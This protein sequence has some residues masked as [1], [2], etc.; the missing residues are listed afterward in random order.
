MRVN[1]LMR[2]CWTA[3][4]LLGLLAAAGAGGCTNR[5][6]LRAQDAYRT[7]DLDR[8][9]QSFEAYAEQAADSG[10][11]VLAFLELGNIARIRGDYR[12]S[13]KAFA[14]AEAAIEQ[15]DRQP[16]IS[17]SREA[18]VTTTNLNAL[19][20]RASHYDRVMLSV[21]RA[22]NFMHLG[23]FDAARVELRR[24]Y[25][26]QAEAVRDN[27]ERIEQARDAILQANRS[28]DRRAAGVDLSR[29]WSSPR[30]KSAVE[31]RF[32]ELEQYQAYADYVNPFAELLQGIFLVHRAADG[33]DLERARL[34]F[35][36]VAGMVPADGYV[37]Q[38]LA[39]AEDLARGQ[40]A[41]PITYVL[42]E[43]GTAPARDQVR[44]NLP[45]FLF[46]DEVDY[47]AASFPTLVMDPHFVRRITVAA[48]SRRYPTRPVADMDSIIAQEF[49]NELPVVIAKT[50]VASSTKAAMAWGVKEATRDRDDWLAATALIA[51]LVYQHA[52]AEADLRTWATLPKQI[53]YARLPTPGSG[54]A[55]LRVPGHEPIAVR[56][57]PGQTNVIM[58]RSI[59]P[60]APLAVSQFSL[61]TSP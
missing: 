34:A 49:R 37:K 43:T 20:Y 41:D 21:Y 58:V 5:S 38:D 54:R 15:M 17:L 14:Q 26:R 44:I 8:A 18:L 51:T 59:H 39:L 55:E 40:G 7:G 36:R 47:F 28:G 29:T 56:V 23:D 30:F 33:D 42:F 4:V 57:D 48:G 50:L 12:A 22:L 25:Q 35:A 11:R 27:A 19:P 3:V 1:R 13:N 2:R 60:R 9:A 61:E 32:A 16:R 53:Q 6:L 52:T 31:S 46:N 10:D 24:A 45:L